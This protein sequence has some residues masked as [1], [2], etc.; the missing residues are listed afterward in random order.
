M[1]PKGHGPTLTEKERNVD[2]VIEFAGGEKVGT[3]WVGEEEEE[4]YVS[5]SCSYFFERRNGEIAFQ[6][7]RTFATPTLN[8][9][10]ANWTADK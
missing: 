3:N 5:L 4:N 8:G 6:A 9:G 7:A 1:Y 10:D 2:G